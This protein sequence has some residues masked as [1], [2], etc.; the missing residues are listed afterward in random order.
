[1][2]YEVDYVEFGLACAD[3]CS[4]L[5]CNLGGKRLNDLNSSVLEAVDQLTT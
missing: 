5:D 4:A 2:I 1:M 3:I